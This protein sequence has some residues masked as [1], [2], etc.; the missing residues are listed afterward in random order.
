MVDGIHIS[1]GQGSQHGA[2]DDLVAQ[3]LWLGAHEDEARQTLDAL[4]PIS[5]YQATAQTILA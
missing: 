3:T 2:G 5:P 1:S 4:H